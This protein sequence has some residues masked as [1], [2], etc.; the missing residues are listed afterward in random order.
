MGLTMFPPNK[1][2]DDYGGQQG[3]AEKERNYVAVFPP[4]G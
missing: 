4:P 2:G 1:D 3:F